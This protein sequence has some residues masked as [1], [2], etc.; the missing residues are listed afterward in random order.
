MAAKKPANK[1]A[2]PAKKPGNRGTLVARDAG[3]KKLTDPMMIRA[4]AHPVRVALLEALTREGPLT[5]TEAGELVGE[6]PANCS[7][8]FRTLAKYGFVE[9]V[10][11]GTGRARPWR[12]VALGESLDLSKLDEGF[13]VAQEFAE[14]SIERFFD[15]ARSYLAHGHTDPPEW[16]VGFA[17]TS[18]LYLTPSE[19]EELGNQVRA[20]VDGMYRERT[21]DIAKRPEGSRAVEYAT[22]GFPLPPT[23]SGR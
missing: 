12:R 14:I 16:Q 4:L 19:L 13:A 15:R 23:P 21:L 20:L 2:A 18:L 22:F 8:H 1:A 3:I 9:E 5:A 6:S 17:N 11:G 10:E 7:F